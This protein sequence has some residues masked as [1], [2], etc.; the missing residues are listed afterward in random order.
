MSSQYYT[1]TCRAL[2]TG[3]MGGEGG[4]HGQYSVKQPMQLTPP[5]TIGRKVIMEVSVIFSFTRG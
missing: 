5:E 1:N 3:V 4:G 2:W